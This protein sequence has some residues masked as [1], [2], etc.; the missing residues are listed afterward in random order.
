MSLG[1][2][3][4]G[5]AAMERENMWLFVSTSCGP[6]PPSVLDGMQIRA[7]WVAIGFARTERMMTSEAIS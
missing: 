3:T 5:A 6:K 2:R 7:A 4:D 1:R